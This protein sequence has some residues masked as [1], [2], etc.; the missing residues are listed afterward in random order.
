MRS[1]RRA[2]QTAAPEVNLVPMMDVLMTVLTFFI[3]V[4]M[5]LQNLKAVDVNIPSS[6]ASP[7]PQDVLPEPMIVELL[8]TGQITVDGNASDRAQLP[9]VMQ[10]YLANQ[11]KGAVL[12]KPTR[13]IKYEM[14]VQLLGEMQ[15][16]GG[17]RV[18]LALEN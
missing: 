11:P 9:T 14:V 8:P 17:D 5:L 1:R 7:S 15:T 12:L 6:Q 2:M 10:G 13:G 3:I 16:I 18:S 4:S